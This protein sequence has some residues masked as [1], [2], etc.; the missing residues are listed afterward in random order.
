MQSQA[1]KSEESCILHGL[2]HVLWLSQYVL[3]KYSKSVLESAYQ[4][5]KLK[6][7]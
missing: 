2:L 5:K 4:A 6:E 7:P 1:V 3:I